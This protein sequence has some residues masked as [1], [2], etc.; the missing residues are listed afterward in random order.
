MPI[1]GL[2]LPPASMQAKKL[3]KEYAEMKQQQ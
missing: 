3:W 1:K 2:L